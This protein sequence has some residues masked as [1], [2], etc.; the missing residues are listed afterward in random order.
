MPIPAFSTNGYLPPGVHAC[1]LAEIRERFGQFQRTDQ[2]CRLMDKL[3]AFIQECS[4][5]GF[6]RSV[7]ID[8]SFMTDRDRPNDIDLIVVLDEL[9]DFK[10]E[11]RPF[12]YNVVS[13]P[14][15]RRRYD[16]D[17]VAAHDRSPE[18]ES[19]IMFFA[20]VRKSNTRKGLV[21]VLL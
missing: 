21:Q 5:M 6:I 10:A 12:E 17:A 20:Q 9:H 15:V 3:E 19:A 18:L 11:L 7:I 1:T 8:G 14:D 16:F 13:K 2:R 4:A